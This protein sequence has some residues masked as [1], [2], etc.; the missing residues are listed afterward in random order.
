[1]T[2]GGCNLER[3]G[4]LTLLVNLDNLTRLDTERRAVDTL[5]VYEDVTV[6]NHLTSLSDGAGDACTQ[7][8]SVEAHLEKLDQV[9]T[10]QA[11]GALGF[12][13]SLAELG[14]ANAVLGAKTLLL[15]QTNGEVAVSLLLGATVLTWSVWTLLE[16]LSGLW[17]KSKSERTRQTSLAASTCGF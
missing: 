7:N 3:L 16:V 11:F 15:A 12:L 9:L 14:L 1:V 5:A 17:S 6:D 4:L 13:E 8:K 10:G 2:A